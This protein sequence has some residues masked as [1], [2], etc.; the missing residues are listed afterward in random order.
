MQIH[1]G[2]LTNP[3]TALGTALIIG[4]SIKRDSLCTTDSDNEESNY[5][6][7]SDEE[8]SGQELLV[9][10]A[11]SHEESESSSSKDEETILTILVLKSV[12]LNLKQP[13]KRFD[14]QPDNAASLLHGT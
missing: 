8:S 3:G 12:H 5:V 9:H 1:F 6:D 4:V 11:E 13:S 14:T 10:E 2:E 7:V